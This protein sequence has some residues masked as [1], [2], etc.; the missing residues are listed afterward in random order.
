MSWHY[1]ELLLSTYLSQDVFH[2]NWVC[3]WTSPTE[4]VRLGEYKHANL[5]EYKQAELILLKK[6]IS[7]HRIDRQTFH[8][9]SFIVGTQYPTLLICH[10]VVRIGNNS[11]KKFG[12]LSV[13]CIEINC[14]VWRRHY[15][16]TSCVIPSAM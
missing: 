8:R 14:F 5:G 6:G 13:H 16:T 11:K 10:H 9:R 15:R 3:C 4:L 2:S 7:W 12:L 1:Q